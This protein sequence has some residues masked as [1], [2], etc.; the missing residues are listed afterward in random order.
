MVECGFDSVAMYMCDVVL[1][2]LF[3]E[4][5]SAFPLLPSFISFLSIVLSGEYSMYPG[6]LLILGDFFFCGDDNIGDNRVR[7]YNGGGRIFVE[8]K[9]QLWKLVLPFYCG[10]QGSRSGHQAS[11]ATLSS[12]KSS[13]RPKGYG[14]KA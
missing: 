12:T 10:F 9:D 5:P 6:I 13:H 1:I 8:V 7:R 2:C 4:I 14:S 11:V 3:G